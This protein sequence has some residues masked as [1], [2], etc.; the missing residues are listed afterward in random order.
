MKKRKRSTGGTLEKKIENAI[1]TYLSFLPD[2]FAWKNNTTGIYDPT[3]GKWRKTKNRFAINGVA[4]ILGVYKGRALAIEVKAP[5]K[6]ATKDQV[7]FLDTF[8]K[9]GGL[10]GVATS[11][12]ETRNI[13]ACYDDDWDD[14][15]EEEEEDDEEY[16]EEEVEP[17]ICDDLPM[18]EVKRGKLKKRNGTSEKREEK[19]SSNR[20]KKTKRVRRVRNEV[21]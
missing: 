9:N 7:D 14:E 8:S 12:D 11:V 15:Y 21:H 20:T 17:D 19:V 13:L 16:E 10:C 4:D 18:L 3:T 5:G 1:L 6:K 2:C